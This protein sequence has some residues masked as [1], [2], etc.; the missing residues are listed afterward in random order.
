V[1]ERAAELDAGGAYLLEA[2][3]AVLTTDFAELCAAI[4]TAVR[5]A[6]GAPR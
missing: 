4:S 3:R 2:D 1:S 6:S 5:T